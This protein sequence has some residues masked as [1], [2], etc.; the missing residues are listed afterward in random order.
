MII[1][2][3]YPES[4]GSITGS[5]FRDRAIS[6][7]SNGCKVSVAAAFVRVRLGQTQ[8]GISVSEHDGIAE[9]RA[10]RRNL[11]PF[12][13]AGIA[14]QQIPMIRQIYERICLERGKP[15]IIHLESARCAPAAI[16]LAREEDIPLTYTEHYSKVLSGRPGSYHVLMARKAVAAASQVFLV[17]S[18][19][20]KKLDPPAEKASMLP[21]AVDFSQFALAKPA[22]P[23]TFCA[24][25]SLRKI[26]GYDI[27]LQAF[28][29]VHQ[30][31]PAC[32]LIIGGSGEEEDAL[33]ALCEELDL[34]DTVTFAGRVSLED[35]SRFFSPASSFVC[36][37]L[38]ETFS[39]VIIEAFACGIPVVAT[40]CGGPEDLVNSTNGFLVEK[41]DPAAL[42]EGMCRMFAERANFDPS[43]IRLAAY[44]VYDQQVLIRQQIDCYTAILSG[45]R[46]GL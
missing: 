40:R 1:A 31:H 25:G 34:K 24:L 9:Y 39:V 23:F 45:K 17:S 11:T 18:A 36:S 30:Q 43:A 35:R 5:F 28:A 22:V 16:H 41:G 32:R 3:W 37:S 10:F 19:M 33:R 44:Q 42:A 6:L 27:L 21:N 13:E 20:K 8:A 26:K 38:T 46:G 4:D 12:F 29:Q 7:A 2:S 14:M 15:D